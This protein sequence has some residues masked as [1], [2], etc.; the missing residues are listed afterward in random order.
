MDRIALVIGN[1]AY[2]NVTPLHNPMNDANDIASILERLNFKVTKLLDASLLDIQAAVNVFYRIWM[3]TQQD[4]CF[5][6]AMVCKSMEKTILF[7]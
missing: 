6:L 5:M 1:S 2:V 3:I 7:L 4:C